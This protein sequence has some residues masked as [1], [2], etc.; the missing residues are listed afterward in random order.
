MPN[1]FLIRKPKVSGLACVAAL[2]NLAG[3]NSGSA[4]E[5]SQDG[6]IA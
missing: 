5:S 2:Q 1:V 6:V 3:G 4:L